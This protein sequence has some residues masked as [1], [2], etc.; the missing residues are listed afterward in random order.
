M[1]AKVDLASIIHFARVWMTKGKFVIFMG[2]HQNSEMQKKRIKK[3]LLLNGIEVDGEGAISF[4]G[5][6][7]MVNAKALYLMRHGETEA[8][9]SHCFMSNN[10]PN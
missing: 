3:I 6:G 10:S 1:I 4:H 8:T 7:S 5:P 2:F 9:R